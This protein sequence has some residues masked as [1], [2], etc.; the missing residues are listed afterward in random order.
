MSFNRNAF[1]YKVVILLETF[2][3]IG[4][5]LIKNEYKIVLIGKRFGTYIFSR[6]LSLS[7]AFRSTLVHEEGAILLGEL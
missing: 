6:N 3:M 5:K 4:C 7:K 2:P 1:K